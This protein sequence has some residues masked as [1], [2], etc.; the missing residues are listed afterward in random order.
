ML[1]KNSGQMEVYNAEI[2][3]MQ[4]LLSGEKCW[5]SQLLSCFLIPAPFPRHGARRIP[6]LLNAERETQG[7]QGGGE[8][9]SVEGGRHSSVALSGCVLLRET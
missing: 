2:F 3:N 9:G 8:T 7:V 6:P 1:D 4:P 5:G